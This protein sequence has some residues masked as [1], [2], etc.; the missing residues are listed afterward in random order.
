MVVTSFT[1]HAVPMLRFETGDAAIPSER[2]IPCAFGL[3]FPVV[4]AITHNAYYIHG[5]Y[6]MS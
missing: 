6:G 3:P 5:F 1:T 2:H 4:E